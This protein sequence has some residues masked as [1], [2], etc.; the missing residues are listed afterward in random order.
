M[1][2]YVLWDLLKILVFKAAFADSWDLKN[3]KCLKWKEFKV[4][5]VCVNSTL[6]TQRS[7]RIYYSNTIV[8]LLA[9]SSPTS[10]N[11]VLLNLIVSCKLQELFPSL[12]VKTNNRSIARDMIWTN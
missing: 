10:N 12:S 8:Y 2:K 4:L 7:L 3:Q 1:R 5:H 11:F 9:T 6:V